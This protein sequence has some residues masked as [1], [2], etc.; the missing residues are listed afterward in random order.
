MK[1]A[2]FDAAAID[3]AVSEFTSTTDARIV[4]AAGKN[5]PA[6]VYGQNPNVRKPPVIKEEE[7][8]G[9]IQEFINT[10]IGII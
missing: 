9:S 8:N 10:D 3:A 5:G 6:T 1:R 4:P 2:L 7:D